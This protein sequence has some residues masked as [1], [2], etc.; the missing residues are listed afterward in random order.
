MTKLRV[1]TDQPEFQVHALS[2]I[3]CNS[4]NIIGHLFMCIST[5][6]L[7][8]LCVWYVIDNLVFLCFVYCCSP[9][10]RGKDAYWGQSGES[11]SRIKTKDKPDHFS[12]GIREDR[13]EI[14]LWSWTLWKE[15]WWAVGMGFLP[16]FSAPR[17]KWGSWESEEE[18]CLCCPFGRGTHRLPSQQCEGGWFRINVTE[19]HRLAQRDLLLAFQTT[20]APLLCSRNPEVPA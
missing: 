4:T 14:L 1:E 12:W 7:K 20:L 9:K 2:T 13:G 6:F 5:V 19:K 16:F 3:L 17:S 15:G 8:Y 10:K 18:L 11:P